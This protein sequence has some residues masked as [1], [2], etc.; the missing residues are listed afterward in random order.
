MIDIVN[1]R[2]EVLNLL[3]EIKPDTPAVFGK[4]TPQHMIEHLAFAVSYSNGNREYPLMIDAEKAEQIKKF[5]IHTTERIPPG[6]KSPLLGDDLPEL[7]CNSID[8]AIASLEKELDDFDRYFREK[9]DRKVMQPVMG[10][11]GHD[12]WVTYHNRHIAHHLSQFGL[13]DPDE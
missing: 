13:Y 6:F 5:T 10:E 8:E 1:Q 11:L 3:R 2:Q 9:P 4:L 12:D 7:K